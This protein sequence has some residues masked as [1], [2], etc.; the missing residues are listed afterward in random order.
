MIIPYVP[1]YRLYRLSR[2]K[3]TH[4]FGKKLIC[5][6]ILVWKYIYKIVENS[7]IISRVID[8][9]G[10]RFAVTDIKKDP[11]KGQGLFQN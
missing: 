9:K 11:G 7:I 8:S 3:I 6:R 4:I 5:F 2:D 1:I 10:E